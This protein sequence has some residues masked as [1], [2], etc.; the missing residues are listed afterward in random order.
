MPKYG[1]YQ[2]TT[3][4]TPGTPPRGP[5]GA[6]SANPITY[7]DLKVSLVLGRGVVVDVAPEYTKISVHALANSPVGLVVDGPGRIK[8]AYQV[9]YEIT[10]Y[11]PADGT[12]TLR[13]AKDWRPGQKDDPH[14]AP[15]T[16]E[17]PDHLD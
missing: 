1:G 14:A 4:T 17:Q 13:L 2:P 6:S 8:V 11:D 9:G 12:L 3:S 5:A 7:E 16:P 10:G 15:T